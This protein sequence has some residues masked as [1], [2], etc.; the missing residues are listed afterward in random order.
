MNAI[1]ATAN[2]DFASGDSRRAR[3]ST[4]ATKATEHLTF[5]AGPC[6][7]GTLMVARNAVG[8]C[9][10]LLGDTRADVLDELQQ[11][12]REQKL[13]PSCLCVAELP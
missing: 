12:F 10:I 11:R 7:L 13:K 3:A 8:V 5:A 9:A 6:S 1:G 2:P 4:T